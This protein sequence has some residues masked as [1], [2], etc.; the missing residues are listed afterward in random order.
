MMLEKP[1]QEFLDRL[2]N[3]EFGLDNNTLV[4]CLLIPVG[5]LN[6]IVESTEERDL[7]ILEGAR[8]LAG[9]KEGDFARIGWTTYFGLTTGN[10]E[11][12]RS[13]IQGAI[14]RS[15]KHNKHYGLWHVAVKN[16]GNYNP[17]K[18]FDELT[19]LLENH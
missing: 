17:G 14:Q 7:V 13:K 9:L 5:R 1:N 2:N 10:A 8:I 12:V 18:L 19:D 15:A 6:H 11:N 4:I 16:L 3:N